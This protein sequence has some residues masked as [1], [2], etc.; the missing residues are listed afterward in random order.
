VAENDAVIGC[1]W[2]GPWRDKA[3][4]RGS[5]ETTIVLAP[6][7]EGQ[8]AGA[9]LYTALLDELT[10]RGFHTAIGVVALPNDASIALHRKLGFREVGALED[11]G[12]KD[13][14]FHSTMILQRVLASTT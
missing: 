2:S 6:G 3:A 5:A 10:D 13:G 1:A 11:V 14:S 7:S 8:G 12:F 4:Y 9:R